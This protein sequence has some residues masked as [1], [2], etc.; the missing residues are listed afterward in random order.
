MDRQRADWWNQQDESGSTTQTSTGAQETAPKSSMR[1]ETQADLLRL[2]SLLAQHYSAVACSLTVTRSF[3]ATRLCTLAAIAAITDKVMRV[4][5]CDIPSHISL[6]YS[7]QAE[8]PIEAFC[9]D[10]SQFAM[11]S[12]FSR[13]HDP[14]LAVVRTRLLDYFIA[15]KKVTQPDHVLF[16]FEKGMNMSAGDVQL[17]TQISLQLGFSRQP[18]NLARYLSGEDRSLTDL[19]PELGYFRD[20]VYLFKVMDPLFPLYSL[21]VCFF[22]FSFFSLLHSFF[23]IFNF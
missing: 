3:D 10:A 19:Y 13:F 22:L 18:E 23:L 7:G 5:A 11:E 2:L 12:E 16:Q 9:F 15:R 8:G 21:F 14:N 20:I 6:H 4:V 1:Y 17:L